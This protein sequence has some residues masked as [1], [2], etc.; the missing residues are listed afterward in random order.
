MNAEI[1]LKHFDRI[2][3]APNAVYRLR[4]FILDLAVRGALVEQDPSD[5]PATELMKRIE[6]VKG[7]SPIA[8]TELGAV[9]AGDLPFSLPSTWC[10][11]RLG[12]AFQ[13][14]CGI[15]REPAELSQDWWLLELEDIEKDTSVVLSRF[16]VAE[17]DS[18]STKSEFRSGDILYGKLR[19]YLNKVVVA[20]EHGYSTTEIVAIRPYVSLCTGYCSI[21]LRRPDF[22]DY[23]NRLGRGTKMP[24]L[25]TPDAVVAL[26]P[27]APVAEQQRITTKVEELMA[28]CDQLAEA[29]DEREAKRR[30]LTAASLHDL[31]SDSE[32]ETS[33]R[34][35]SFFISH[36]PRLTACPDQIKQF[37][38]TVLTLAVR[39]TLVQQDPRD[40][41][42]NTLL[43]EFDRLRHEVA[44][45]DRRAD[46]DRQELLA[47]ELK[48][49][50]PSTWAW[51]ALADLVLFIDYRGKTPTKV[52]RGMRLITA[53]NVRKGFISLSP[54][55]F[56]TEAAYGA[57]MTR[58]LP[59]P[60]DILFTT[61]APMG[62][63]AVVRL[64]ER[65]ALAQRVI[66]FRPYA[67]IN[68]DFLALQLLSEPFQAILDH[69]ATGLTAKGIKGA[70]LRRLPVVIPPLAEQDRIVATVNKLLTVCDGL[71]TQ[72]AYMKEESY[73][74]LRAVLHQ[75]LHSEQVERGSM[76][77]ELR[78]A[79]QQI[80]A[81][82]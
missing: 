15:K 48:W 34:R 52:E 45:V 60:G 51:S 17:R 8:V 64:E 24:R 12:D 49:P 67:S 35:A 79:S 9:P 69:T 38:E 20:P 36:L 1:L 26:F 73:R 11:V 74:L 7:A 47:T 21:A 5:E 18:R 44:E 39:G 42:A 43:L 82:S 55:E 6:A 28:L 76:G 33:R 22:V 81:L 37:R 13:Y 2:S 70:K 58:G 65:F 56:L 30:R 10:W 61:E 25:R 80:N 53:K 3:E 57:W 16:T 40:E 29:Q 41:S 77:F 14:D 23:V 72:I 75:A 59:R 68:V 19:P 32:K 31:T 46:A 27:M 71:E 63:A 62:N 78:A 54:E 66:C 4:Q 50:V